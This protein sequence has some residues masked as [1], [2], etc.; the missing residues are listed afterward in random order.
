MI[1]ELQTRAASSSNY[2]IDG[3][4]DPVLTFTRGQT[5]VFQRNDAGHAFYVKSALGSGSQGRY[6][7]GVVNN[8]SADPSLD[9]SF[10]VPQ[11]APDVLYY[12]CGAHYNMQG[13]I[14][15]TSVE[16]TVAVTSGRKSLTVIANVSG[17]QL[18]LENLN[19]TVSGT[20]HTIEYN[21][22]AY[23]YAE[24]NSVITTVVRDG[25]F[26]N[27]FAQE[28]AEAFPNH[29]GI[30]YSDAVTL[31]GQPNMEAT[32]MAIANADG[33]YFG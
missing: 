26:T 2:E 25:E 16:A 17:S 33:N 28:I 14:L 30:S 23:N 21:G 22:T 8:G 10:V 19:E 3:K 6:D 11:N 20:T 15:V 24:V 7:A 13:K 32:L 4:L 5:Y 12:Q 29:A 31:I 1:I 9:V 18:F 27:E